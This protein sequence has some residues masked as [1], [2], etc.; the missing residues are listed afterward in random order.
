M[1]GRITKTNSEALA[2]AAA[3][4][5]I[6]GEQLIEEANELEARAAVLRRPE[7][8][9]GQGRWAIDVRFT[10][11]GKLYQFLVLRAGNRYY[12][13]GTGEASVFPSWRSFLA[14]LDANVVEHSAMIPLESDFSADPALEGKRA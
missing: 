2:I 12:T 6:A 10:T 1:S 8:S 3:A 14:W 13:T 7:P 9:K 4:K 5:R 11:G